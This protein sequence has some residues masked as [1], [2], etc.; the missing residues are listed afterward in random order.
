MGGIWTISRSMRAL[1]GT[2][3]IRASL[4]KGGSVTAT[5]TWP[6]L[7]YTRA[8]TG[9][10]RTPRTIPNRMR[11][12]MEAA[13]VAVHRR[14]IFFIILRYGKWDSYFLFNKK[15]LLKKPGGICN[16]WAKAAP[17]RQG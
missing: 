10:S 7:R 11:N 8:A 2:F 5:G 6:N 16:S 3:V 17:A 9:T 15:I 13:S 14:E 1:K 12:I 4:G